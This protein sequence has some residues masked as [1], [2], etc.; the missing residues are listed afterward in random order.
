MVQRPETALASAMPNAGFVGLCLG[1]GH[2]FGRNRPASPWRSL[3]SH[4]SRRPNQFTFLLVD[5]LAENLLALEGHC[6]AAT[7]SVQLKAR[8]GAEALEFLLSYDIALALVDVQMP[9][10]DGFELAELMRGT[11]R[12]RRVPIIFLTAGNADRQRRFRGY[13]TGAVDFL[14]KPIEPD[15]I[16]SKCEV[17]FELYRQRQEVARQRDEL[18]I[19]TEENARLLAESRQYADALQDAAKRKDEF[20]AMLAHELRN[21]LA[22]VGH[23]VE[24]LRITSAGDGVAAKAREIIARQVGH[25]AR[26]VDDLLDVARIARGRVQL[27]P[28]RCDLAAIVRQTAEDY[29]PTLASSGVSLGVDMPVGEIAVT[30]DPTRLAQVVGNLLHNAGKFTEQGGRV[31]VGVSIDG[32]RRSAVVRVSDTGA[33]MEGEVLARLFE[34]FSQADQNLDRSKGGLGLGL[35]LVRELAELHGGSVTAESDGPG[36]GSTFTLCLPLAAPVEGEGGG[37]GAGDR[38]AAEPLR[39]VVV[40]DNLDAAEILQMLLSMQGH[41]IVV[42]HDGSAGL[43][44]IKEHVPDVVVSDL[45]LPGT[46]DGYGLARAVKADSELAGIYLIALSGYGRDEDRRRAK[47]CGF[48]RHLVKPVDPTSLEAALGLVQRRGVGSLKS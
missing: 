7:D 9:G 24:V 22:P 33:G 31:D 10:M 36:L 19:A 15:I 3:P 12:T 32:G 26:L 45:G 43:A 18:R 40:E 42:A 13:E 21:P 39:I 4:D 28:E 46:L 5:D 38:P 48:D 25:M 23:A 47:D 44:A 27:R 35:A 11:E 16:R 37:D 34:P 17:F 2:D 29:R 41:K 8:S 6:C 1:A 30:G 20:L 14:H